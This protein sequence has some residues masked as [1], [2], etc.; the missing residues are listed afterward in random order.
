MIDQIIMMLL[1][2]CAGLFLRKI[3]VFTDGVIKGINKTLLMVATLGVMLL[4]EK[5]LGLQSV[6]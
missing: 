1:I 6:V 5:T 3:G 2:A 4:I